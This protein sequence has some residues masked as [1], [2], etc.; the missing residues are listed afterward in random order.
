LAAAATAACTS[1][2]DGVDAD[3][4]AYINAIKAV[5]AHAHPL[6]YV[7]PGAPADSEFDALPLDK[8]PPFQVPIG[9]RPEHPQY[10]EAQ[11]AL[12]GTSL[13]DTGAAYAKAL[14]SARNAVTKAQGDKY[15]VWALDHAG[16]EQMMS[17]RIV[18][19]AGLPRDR[20][21]WI[22]FADALM[23][24]LDIHGEAARTPDVRSLYPL[25]AKLLDRYLHDLGLATIPPTLDTYEQGVV[26]PTLKRQK[27]AGAV[28]IKFEA[29][30]IRSLDFEPVDA[31]TARSIY[32]RYAGGGV[33]THAE[34]TTLEDY[35][36]RVIAREAGRQRLTIQ[37]HA[38]EGFGGFYSMTGSSPLL[39]ESVF[40]DSTL[41][42]TNF[43]ITHG[44]WPRVQET[45]L[46]LGKPNVYADISMFDVLVTPQ[47]MS[48]TLR[49]WLS[50]W[51]EKVLF[52]TDAFD[53]GAAQG[54][55]QI[56]WVA[57]HNARK[58]LA[59]ALS[60]MMRDNEITRPRAQ[61]IAR[62]VLRENARVAY[63]L[64]A[65]K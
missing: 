53:G 39:L 41:R 60:G 2:A 33:P 19:G 25:E 24:P 56:A 17:N 37:I 12:F 47:V 28:G 34:Y 30:Y 23:L 52:G 26:I 22:P 27:D 14:E 11:H 5:D 57:S 40:N 1:A 43:V 21:L 65:H 45:Q 64:D 13:T 8:L 15:P 42:G 10:R 4:S 38:T 59:I 32:A 36:F 58:A 49:M 6:R 3:L 46:M 48:A 29:A 55:E 31:Q 9:L 51:P 35:L 18:M 44:G 54:W 16:I 20:F 61:E 62:M 50:E 63:H 7:P